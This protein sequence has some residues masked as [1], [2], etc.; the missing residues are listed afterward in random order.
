MDDLGF[1]MASWARRASGV[2][3]TGFFCLLLDWGFEWECRG[4]ERWFGRVDDIGNLF[5][6]LLGSGDGS[7]MGVRCDEERW[8]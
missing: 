3:L 6:A 1:S 5:Q 7:E 8:A 4:E 2:S